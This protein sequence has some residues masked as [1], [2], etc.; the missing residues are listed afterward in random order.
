MS[1]ERKWYR[2][3]NFD[4]EKEKLKQYYPK[5]NYRQAYSDIKKF[6]KE[7]GFVHRQWSGYRSKEMLTNYQVYKLMEK[8]KEE[9]AWLPLCARRFDVTNIM[10]VFDLIPYLRENTIVKNK[11]NINFYFEQIELDLSSPYDALLTKSQ[12]LEKKMKD[13]SIRQQ[14]QVNLSPLKEVTS[15]KNLPNI[16]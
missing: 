3:F 15:Q 4:L 8:M 6:L 13:A 7:N 5:K 16:R 14:E 1:D 11:D 9:F 2:A 12:S 10:N